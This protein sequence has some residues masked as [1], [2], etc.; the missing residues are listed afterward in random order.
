M[1]INLPGLGKLIVSH[2]LPR[3]LL[4]RFFLGSLIIFPQAGHWRPFPSWSI[5]VLQFGHF[6]GFVSC[7]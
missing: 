1:T 4:R 7:L 2:Y 3:F 6:M 5:L